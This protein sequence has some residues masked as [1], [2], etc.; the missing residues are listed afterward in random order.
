MAAVVVALICNLMK[1]MMSAAVTQVSVV[2]S[3]GYSLL[4]IKI[5]INSNSHLKKR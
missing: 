5:K 1:L 3:A 4:K 2:N